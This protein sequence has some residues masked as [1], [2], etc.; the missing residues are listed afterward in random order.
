MDDNKSKF[1]R[2]HF[3]DPLVSFFNYVLGLLKYI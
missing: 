2:K 3:I 1:K